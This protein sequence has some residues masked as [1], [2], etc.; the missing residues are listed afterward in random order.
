MA[1]LIGGY[2]KDSHAVYATVHKAFQWEIWVTNAK[3]SFSFLYL[4]YSLVISSFIYLFC[5]V[6]MM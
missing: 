3:I 6:K 1:L 5:C 4:V 2:A